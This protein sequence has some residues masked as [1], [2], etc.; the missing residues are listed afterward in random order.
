[1]KILHRL[2]QKKKPFQSMGEK[3]EQSLN[4]PETNYECGS[5]NYGDSRQEEEDYSDT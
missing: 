1:M 5:E 3:E 2:R 4:E